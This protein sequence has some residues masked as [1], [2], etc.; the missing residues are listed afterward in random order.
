MVLLT[1]PCTS[2]S[3]SSPCIVSALT[4]ERP[5]LQRYHNTAKSPPSTLQVQQH[6]PAEGSQVGV[7]RGRGDRDG[8]GGPTVQVAEPVREQLE[9]VR[10]EA[11]LVH[12]HVV[13]HRARRA[14][15]AG[16]RHLKK[17]NSIAA[18]VIRRDIDPTL[19]TR[20]SKPA[21]RI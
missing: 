17:T 21:Q 4:S 20:W 11:V 3:I 19:R 12:Q 7:V 5:S 16:V 2:F 8:A 15:D 1:D 10:G 9:A 13:A 18:A 6:A 14:L